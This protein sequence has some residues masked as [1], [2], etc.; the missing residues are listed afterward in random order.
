MRLLKRLY[1]QIPPENFLILNYD[2]NMNPKLTAQKVKD[3][4]NS[5]STECYRNPCLNPTA[6]LYECIQASHSALHLSN[7]KLLYW[8]PPSADRPIIRH[9]YIKQASNPNVTRRGN[10]TP[11]RGILFCV[12]RWLLLDAEGAGVSKRHDCVSRLVADANRPNRLY[13]ECHPA[14]FPSAEA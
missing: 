12:T 6:A 5:G 7:K 10:Y 2:E 13:P 4:N 3:C 1:E 8:R 11:K 9:S 14:D